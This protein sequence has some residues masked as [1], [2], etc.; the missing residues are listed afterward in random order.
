M[1]EQ[2]YLAGLNEEGALAVLEHALSLDGIEPRHCRWSMADRGPL[3]LAIALGLP[4]A[5][6]Q[7]CAEELAASRPG[8]RLEA[9]PPAGQSY[10]CASGLLL[11]LQ[12][13]GAGGDWEPLADEK[14]IVAEGIDQDRAEALF[15]EISFGATATRVAAASVPGTERTLWLFHAKDD[16]SRSSTLAGSEKSGAFGDCR[17][18]QAYEDEGHSLFFPEGAFPVRTRFRTLRHLLAKHPGL[19]GSGLPERGPV[20]AGIPAQEEGG[21][22]TILWLAGLKFVGEVQ[23]HPAAAEL[24]EVRQIELHDAATELQQLQ[25]RI[26]EAGSG[27]GYPL[28]L[29]PAPVVRKGVSERMHLRQ[30]LAETRQRLA[31][32]E[33]LDQSHPVLYRFGQTEL[34]R[35]ADLLSSFPVEVLK[36]GDLQYAFYAD[37][38][39]PEGAHFLLMPPEHAVFGVAPSGGVAFQIDPLWAGAYFEPERPTLVFVPAGQR[40]FPSMHAWNASEMESY[41]AESVTTWSKAHGKVPSELPAQPLYVFDEVTLGKNGAT[42]DHLR[43]SVLDRGAFAPLHERMGWINDNLTVTR[44]I[45][46]EAFVANMAEAIRREEMLAEKQ[47]RLARREKD[48]ETALGTMNQRVLT[49]T[50]TFLKVLDDRVNKSLDQVET[51]RSEL[52]TLEG[53]LADLQELRSDMRKSHRKTL[54]E[55]DDALQRLPAEL[56]RVKLTMD[57]I[58][59]NA[60]Q[61]REGMDSAMRTEMLNL[62]ASRERLVKALKRELWLKK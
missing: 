47:S 9:Q 60:R 30:R 13:K 2:L 19:L 20:L 1:A 4:E 38:I 7:T 10:D 28:H 22:L 29:R 61:E 11:L 36:N 18:L 53:A 32:L 39:H 31:Y 48:F 25:S 5:A 40:L 51:M 6:A 17:I 37:E 46:T 52:D 62:R 24:P 23:V 35:F 3:G 34:E 21:P 12:P 56:R 57:K 14:L 50:R 43:V 44:D 49:Q 55:V 16:Q 27:G 59:A 15:R 8:L 41:L 42:S 54:G 58:L 26:A 33:S 45:G